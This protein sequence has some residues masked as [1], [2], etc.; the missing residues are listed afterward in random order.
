MSLTTLIIDYGD[1]KKR[2]DDKSQE[3]KKKHIKSLI[4][5]IPTDKEALFAY[6]ID[7]EM[8]DTVSGTFLF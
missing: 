6:I 7:W 1:E 5:K 2:K 4:E 8:V 3:D